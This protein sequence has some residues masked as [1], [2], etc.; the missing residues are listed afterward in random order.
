MGSSYG[1]ELGGEGGEED[2]E[3]IG[4]I[5]MDF[6]SP[7]LLARHGKRNFDRLKVV[8]EQDFTF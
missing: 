5:R 2:E 3:L 1:I 4:N 8:G 7:E 6:P